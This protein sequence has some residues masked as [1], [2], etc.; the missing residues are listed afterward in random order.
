MI[1]YAAAMEAAVAIGT[2]AMSAPSY[3]ATRP[4]IHR[5]QTVIVYSDVAEPGPSYYAEIYPNGGGNAL[6]HAP[7]TY[8][9]SFSQSGLTEWEYSFTMPSGGTNNTH[10]NI[11]IN[12]LAGLHNQ[13][14]L[15]ADPHP[16]TYWAPFVYN[17]TPYAVGQAPEVPFAA[18]LPVLAGLAGLVMW[19]SRRRLAHSRR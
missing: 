11:L 10:Y 8:I 7:L 12:D 4:T 16:G 5:G 15:L 2:L 6:A 18:G 14:R 13:T 1:K 17:A 3:A 19:R 9:K